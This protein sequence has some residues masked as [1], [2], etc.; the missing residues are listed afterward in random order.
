MAES[1]GAGAARFGLRHDAW[2]RPVL[3]LDGRDHVGVE[4]FRA[5][6]FAAPR[7]M[8]SVCSAEGRE[9]LW[10]DDLDAVPADVRAALEGE[11]AR[12]DFVPV[13]RGVLR[14]SAVEPSEWEV[15][16]DRGRTRFLLNSEDD[17]HPL[18]GGRALITDSHGAR[19]LIADLEALDPHSRRLLERYL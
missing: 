10:I 17:I 18:T 13:V 8:V 16:T 3:S 4:V 14:V 7:R 1:G 2:G 5:F 15:E 12:R 19:Y 6:P 9:L 11:L